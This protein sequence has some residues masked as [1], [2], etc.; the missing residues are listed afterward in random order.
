V[1]HPRHFTGREAELDVLDV[2]P[3]HVGHDLRTITNA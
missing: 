1:K 3:A 2:A